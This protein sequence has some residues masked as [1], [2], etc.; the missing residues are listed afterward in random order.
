MTVFSFVD[1]HPVMSQSEIVEHFKTLATGALIF[2][3]GTLSQK[4]RDRPRLDARALQTPNALSM[5]RA[6]IVT[7]P[8]VDR[9]LWLWQQSM[10]AKGESTSGPMLQEKRARFEVIMKIP[11]EERLAGPGWIASWKKACASLF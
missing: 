11:E 7:A 5:K 3:Q 9:A 6:R 1:K 10:Q 2:D 8:A 4:L